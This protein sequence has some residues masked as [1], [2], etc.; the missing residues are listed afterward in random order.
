[1]IVMLTEDKIHKLKELLIFCMDNAHFLR[2]RVIA[3]LTG[4]LV[5]SLPAVKYG[6]LGTWKWIR[7]KLML[8]NA[9]REILMHTWLSQGRVSVKCNGGYATLMGALIQFAIPK[10]M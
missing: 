5:S 7:I 4:H 10:L 8:L 9:P 2:I 6:T 1:M 3:R